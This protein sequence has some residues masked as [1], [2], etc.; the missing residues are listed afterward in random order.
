MIVKIYSE[1]GK[2]KKS[3]GGEEE[4]ILEGCVQKG[5]EMIRT[6]QD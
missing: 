6:G 3:R 1:R 2:N 4:R 5:K